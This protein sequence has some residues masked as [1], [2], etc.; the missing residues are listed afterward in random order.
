MATLEKKAATT[1]K[2]SRL[3]EAEDEDARVLQD[4]GHTQELKVRTHRTL[5]QRPLTF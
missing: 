4:L 1:E 3:Q 2:V 5:L